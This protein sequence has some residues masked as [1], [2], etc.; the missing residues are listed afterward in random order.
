M[1]STTSTSTTPTST[2]GSPKTSRRIVAALVAGGVALAGITAAVT[3]TR[4]TPEAHAQPAATTSS[5]S[6]SSSHGSA[7]SHAG[8]HT[9][10]VIP[11]S[12]STKTLQS[13]LA[14]LNYYDGHVTG[15]WNTQTTD[16]VEYLQAS[17]HLPQTGTMNAATQAALDYQLVHGDNQ[18]GS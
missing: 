14:Q 6:T 13:Q 18:M 16:A 17:A 3:M 7:G 12:Q 4:A 9:P 2:T 11:W 1:T 15:Y 5:S 8:H 10:P